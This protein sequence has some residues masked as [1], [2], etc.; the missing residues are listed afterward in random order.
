MTTINTNTTSTSTDVTLF[1]I[2]NADLNKYQNIINTQF[3]DSVMNKYDMELFSILKYDL[4]L[5]NSLL[6]NQNIAKAS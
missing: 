5:N 4:S 6:Q 1:N 3:L 2:I